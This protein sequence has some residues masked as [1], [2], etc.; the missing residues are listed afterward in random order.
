MK[1]SKVKGRGLYA[2][3]N[4]KAGETIFSERP[5]V[6]WVPPNQDVAAN[7]Y[8]HHCLKPLDE[9]V[10]AEKSGSMTQVGSCSFSQL[11]GSGRIDCIFRK[12]ASKTIGKCPRIS[13][14]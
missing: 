2:K 3:Q 12:K 10:Y 13:W 8:C 11:T 14:N 7:L 1:Y 6:Y 9:L 4:L 5:M